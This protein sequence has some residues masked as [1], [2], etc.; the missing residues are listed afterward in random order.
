MNNYKERYKTQISMNITSMMDVVF[1]LLIIFII[2][3][4]LM[5]AEVDVRLPKSTAATT[6]DHTTV[7]ITITEDAKI[8]VGKT[9]IDIEELPEQIKRMAA[10]GRLTSIS[11]K[12]DEGVNYG[13]VMRVVGYIKDAG[14]ENLGLV[15]TPERRR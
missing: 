7:T 4:P 3:A 13:I 10:E 11:L 1:M 15:A 2:S 9:E 8:Y 12:G 6:R 14:I 5:R